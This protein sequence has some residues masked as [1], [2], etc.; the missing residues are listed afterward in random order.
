MVAAFPNN[1]IVLVYGNAT[2]IV[3]IYA[4]KDCISDQKYVKHALGI[5]EEG[6]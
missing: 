4:I 6:F 3:H 1:A 2:H 5:V